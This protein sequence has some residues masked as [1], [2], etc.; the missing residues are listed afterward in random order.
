MYISWIKILQQKN[1]WK[2][3]DTEPSIPCLQGVCNVKEKLP[4]NLFGERGLQE[5]RVLC[6]IGDRFDNLFGD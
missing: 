5:E 3:E 1:L 2:L 4:E 6:Q